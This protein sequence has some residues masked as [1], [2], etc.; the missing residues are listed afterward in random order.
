MRALLVRINKRPNYATRG[1]WLFDGVP[2]CVT[3]ELPWRENQARMS[4]IP[5]GEYEVVECARPRYTSKMTRIDRPW[6]VLNV[7][8]RGG[9][10]IH[11]GNIAADTSGCILL[12]TYF[13]STENIMGSVLAKNRWH[14][15]LGDLKRFTLTV[16]YVPGI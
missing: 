8:E 5:V 6:E 11:T 10:L 9:I 2:T 1:I 16:Q 7:P 3:L 4:C 14:D 13:G 15:V 12:G